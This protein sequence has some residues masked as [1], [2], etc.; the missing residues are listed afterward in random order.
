M[1][2][3]KFLLILMFAVSKVTSH[4]YMVY[5]L[6]RQRH[7]Y[8]QH[9][10]NWPLDGSGIKNEG[11]R[12]AYQHVYRRNGRNS[13]AAQAMFNQ[14]T[15][16]AALAGGRYNNM[17]HIMNEV[18]PHTLCGAGAD[19]ANK[20]FGDKSGMDIATDK[21]FLNVLPRDTKNIYFCPTVIH[22]PSFFEVY[23]S[24]YNNGPLKWSD[25]QLVY[26]NKS[27]LVEKWLKDCNSKKVYVM[28]N[29]KLPKLTT[30]FVIYVRWQREDIMGE[31][32]YNCADVIWDRSMT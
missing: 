7:C 1:S 5:P 28:D 2:N 27:K 23:V 16:Y 12:L 15:E 32:F 14:N 25:L 31:G 21:W 22:E 26:K 29:I 6:A 11:C 19:K 18:V 4:G 13:A 3:T 10:Y 24:K 9:D 17:T 30:P 8:N 20:Q